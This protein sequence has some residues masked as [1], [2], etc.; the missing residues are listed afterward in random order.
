MK[1]C[2]R[3][4]RGAFW[5][6]ASLMAVIP[7]AAFAQEVATDSGDTAWIMTSLAMVLLMTLGLALFYA[8]MVRAKNVLSTVMHSF[9]AGNVRAWTC[10]GT[11]KGA[12]SW[13][14]DRRS[15]RVVFGG[16][17]RKNRSLFSGCGAAW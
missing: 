17:R 9:F 12:T 4:R 3:L 1:L 10:P 7:S 11:A 14:P 6:F 16:G 13:A 5:A 2:C 15:S 8:G